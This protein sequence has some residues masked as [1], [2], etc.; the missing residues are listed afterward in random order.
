MNN[1]NIVQMPTPLERLAGLIQQDL[2]HCQHGITKTEEGR[3]QWRDGAYALCLHL[4][5]A[6]GHYPANIEFGRWCN[7]NGFGEDVIN[8]DTRAAAIDM[9][10]EPEALRACL[11]A[12][13][14]SSILTV[15]RFDFPVLTK[16]SKR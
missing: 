9:A 11:D 14:R 16:L 8:H 3:R 12:T 4:A 10:K 5:E 1:E 7:D 13:K 15:Q 6:K 2:Q